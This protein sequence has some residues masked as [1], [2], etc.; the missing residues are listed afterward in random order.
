[1][2][3]VR[4]CDVLRDS[5][6]VF[7]ASLSGRVRGVLLAVV[8]LV[9]AEFVVG[10][11]VAA[12][13]AQAVVTG[14]GGQYVPMPSNARVLGGA[15]EK[16]VFRTVKVAGVAGGMPFGVWIGIVIALVAVGGALAIT[17]GRRK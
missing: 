17:R 6:R 14:S 12:G 13:P 11:G 5:F 8:T 10:G 1:M 3:A 16:G 9:A 15:T 7:A 2:G 4:W